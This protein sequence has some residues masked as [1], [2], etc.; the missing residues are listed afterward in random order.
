MRI[1]LYK[2]LIS[3]TPSGLDFLFQEGRGV[4]RRIS[5]FSEKG[6][7]IEVKFSMVLSSVL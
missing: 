4:G 7:V 6:L 3:A 5:S 1:K 2:G